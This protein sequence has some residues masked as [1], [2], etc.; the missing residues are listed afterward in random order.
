LVDFDDLLWRCVHAL[1][2][3]AEFAA[4]QRWRFRHFFVDEFQDVN[5]VQFRLLHAW[6]GEHDAPDL[7]VVGDPNQ[8][9]YSWNGA[10]ASYLVD[11]TTHFPTAATVALTDNYRSTPQILAVANAVLGTGGL[12]ATVDA[13]PVPL[14]RTFDSAQDEARG[15]ARAVRRAHGNGTRWSDMAVLVRTNAQKAELE[16]AFR[17]LDVPCRSD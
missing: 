14:V 11:F 1:E 8:A 3:D 9:I 15:I 5:P 7:C 13:G 16:D 4:A 2:S 17:A 10:D 12:T 6:L